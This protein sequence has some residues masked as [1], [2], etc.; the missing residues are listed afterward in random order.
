MSN[1]IIQFGGKVFAISPTLTLQ[2]FLQ[3]DLYSDVKEE[4]I[5]DFSRFTLLPQTFNGIRLSVSLLFGNQKKI[6]LVNISKVMDQD[7][8]WNSWSEQRELERKKE[9][10]ILLEKLIGNTSCKYTWGEITSDY[11]PR[12]GSSMITIRYF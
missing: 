12:S 1:G 7:S 2:D 5:N 6:F 3:S 8:S 11:D 10:D 4:I 9:H